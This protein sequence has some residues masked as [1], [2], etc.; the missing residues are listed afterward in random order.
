MLL[1][2]IFRKESIVLDFLKKLYANVI[3]IWGIIIILTENDLDEIFFIY[4]EIIFK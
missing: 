4:V 2:C 3:N 1:K